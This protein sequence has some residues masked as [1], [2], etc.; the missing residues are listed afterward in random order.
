MTLI[1]SISGIRG[2]IGGDPEDGLNPLA[3]VKFV[4]AYATFIRKN[5]KVTSNKIVVGRDARISGPMVKEVVLGTLTG[6]GL[7]VVDIDLATTPTTELAVAMEGACGGIILTA[8]HNPKQWNALKLLN[9]RGEFLNAAEG[10]E[11]LRIAAA[12]E[13]VFADVDHLGHVTV[14]NTYRQKHIESVLNLDLVDVEAIRAANFRVAI[15]CV[16][17]VGGLVIPELL[18]ALGVQ[19]I[20]KLHCA[21]HGNFA[22][23]PEPLP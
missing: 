23:N 8:S 10:A 14:D 22:H 19:E 2:T 18:H 13:F 4:A 9:E 17:S 12:E 7:D 20:F 15:D 5:T 6:M 21:P 3:I 11:V 1:K 16:N